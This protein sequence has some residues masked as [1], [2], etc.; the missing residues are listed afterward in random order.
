MRF[1]YEIRGENIMKTVII[2]FGLLV[3]FTCMVSAE[4]INIGVI[5]PLSGPNSNF[6]I[7]ALEGINLAFEVIRD[8]GGINGVFLNPVIKDNTGVPSITSQEVAGLIGQKQVMAII[9]PLTSNNAAAAGAVAQQNNTPL[10]LPTATSPFV[11]EM[12]EYICRICFTDPYQSRAL[13]E[14]AK[15]HLKSEKVAVVF[16]DGSLYS[17]KLAEFFALSLED[18]GG[19]IVFLE[20]FEHESGNLQLVLDKALEKTPDL[21]FVPVYYP[22]AAAVVNYLSQIGSTTTLLGGDGWESAELFRL[23]G[24]NIRIRQVYISSHFS[25]QYLEQSGSNFGEEFQ[26]VHGEPPNAFSALGYDAVMVLAD[27]L[28]RT[29][30]LD[31][32]SLRQAL[33]TTDS[34]L[35]V[36][37]TI[38]INEKRNA[39]KGVY[40]LK[41]LNDRFVY[42]TVI[43]SF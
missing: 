43:P 3:Y 38:S 23:A 36:T 24:E 2:F 6:G 9:G 29:T 13:A 16:E 40:I 1:L 35:G 8:Q 5:L 7:D 10:V 14:F 28:K 41:A 21:L 20:S 25:L 18:I 17:E 15:N 22:E 37:G 12:S 34:Y 42:E 32:S 33:V 30:S 4:D 11:T 26:N 31:K 27:A 19:K 39:I